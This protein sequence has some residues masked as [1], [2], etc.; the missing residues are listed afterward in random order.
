MPRTPEQFE[1]IREEKRRHIM[2]VALELFAQEGY[3]N[4]SISRIAQVAGISK[5]LMYNYFD[6]K[7]DLVQAVLQ[8]GL[9]AL[10]DLFD[11]NK[12][13]VLTVGE[14]DYFVEK[15]FDTIQSNRTY[16]KLYFGIIMQTGIYAMIREKYEVVLQ[17]SIATL[18][19]Y[20]RKQG[21]E[22]PESEAILFGAIMDG[23][24]M[25]YVL[26]P[27]MYPLEKMKKVI[28]EKFRH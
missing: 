25:N 22:E 17:E 23:I 13:G 3:H 20:Y 11:P 10:I 18:I 26:A 19:E 14:F 7:E 4:T 15:T 12:D 2:D 16:W 27:E 24:S 1:K 5:G 6:S 9:N 8:E 21:V 28:I